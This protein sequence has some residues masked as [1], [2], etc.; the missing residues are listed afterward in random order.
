MTEINEKIGEL[1]SSI[2]ELNIKIDSLLNKP[3]R[4]KP[5]KVPCELCGTSFP[6]DSYYKQHLT[7]KKHQL[8]VLLLEEKNRKE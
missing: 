5:L 1:L 6:S 8:A 3:P 4:K 2:K 7:T